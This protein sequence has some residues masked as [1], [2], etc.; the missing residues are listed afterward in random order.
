MDNIT[1]I[2]VVDHQD[3]VIQGISVDVSG[4]DLDALLDDWTAHL[5][6]H[7]QTV[8]GSEVEVET[9]WRRGPGTTRIAAYDSAG[10]EI[11]G[12]YTTQDIQGDT[13]DA[14][15]TFDPGHLF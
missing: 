2:V 9:E 13:E 10:E 8:Y 4:V 1:R 6:A 5:R 7:L 15:T 14:W 12:G 11:L 3:S